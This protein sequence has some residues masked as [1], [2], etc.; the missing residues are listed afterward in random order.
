MSEIV[1]RDEAVRLLAAGGVVAVPTDTVY[2]VAASL[3]HPFAVANLFAMKR[4]PTTAA[5]PV[6][7]DSLTSIEGLGVSWPEK[8]R[9]LSESFWPG[10]LTIVVSVPHEL[11]IL[12]GSTL[13]TV[14]FRIPDDDLLL[15]VLGE[16]GP[17]V[18]SSANEHGETPCQSADEVLGTF[19]GLRSLDGVLDD[20]ERSGNVSTV[21]EVHGGSWRI[22]RHGA[23]SDDDVA[24][25]LA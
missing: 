17:L 22:L 8:A 15:D 6:L 21:V 23:I 25:V 12:V 24:R 1:G 13:D 19:V 9:R 18:V 16:S 4:R 7:L 2:G 5:L 10:A 14:G 20:G 11:A 3:T